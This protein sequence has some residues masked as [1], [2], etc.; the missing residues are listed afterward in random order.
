MEVLIVL[1]CT[2]WL[3][4]TLKMYDLS[5]TKE[6]YRIAYVGVVGQAQDIVIGGAGFLFRCCLTGATF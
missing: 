3:A 1:V 5:L 4:E 6:P 2:V